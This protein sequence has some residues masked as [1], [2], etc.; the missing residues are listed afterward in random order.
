MISNYTNIFLHLPTTATEMETAK[1]AWILLQN[2]FGLIVGFLTMLLILRDAGVSSWGIFSTALS[3]GL[4]FSFV[5]DLGINTAHTR[6]IALGKYRNEYNN[7]LI[8]MKVILT[9]IYVGIILLAVFVWTTVLH[10]HFQSPLIYISILFLIPY[11]VGLPYIQANRAFFTGT[12]EAF[13]MSL[14]P[15]MESIARF[16]SIVIF[17]HFNIFHFPT[18]RSGIPEMA[19]LIAVSYSISYAVYAIVSFVVGMPWNFKWPRLEMIR[20]YL[21]YSYPLIGV[22]IATAISTNVPQVLVYIAF[23]SFQSGGFATDYRLILMMTGFTMSVTVLILPSLTSQFASNGDYGKTMGVSIK[24][25]TLF[26]TPLTVFAT[27]FAA[28]ILNLWNSALI[29][30]AFPLQVMLIGSWFWTMA[31]PFWTHFN[32]VAKT[33]ITALLTNVGY[34]LWIV[35]SIVLIPRTL[36][37]VHLGG[38]GV[39]GGAYSYLISGIALL[40][41]S[42]IALLFEV[43]IKVTY[44]SARSAVM[45]I[46]LGG[47]FYYFFH[48][49][50]R[51]SIFI[52]I[53]LF[54]AYGLSYLGLLLA[55]KAITKEELVDISSMMNPGKLGHY[56]MDELRKKSD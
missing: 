25:L 33:K 1:P 4:V 23:G 54:L 38:L 13:K 37:D 17:L 53:G 34:V 43:R 36:A 8:F 21:K 10:Q 31:I 20:T 2:G 44:Q 27:I 29:A 24:Y 9:I 26:V 3:F 41:T 6:M 48:G 22:S 49:Y 14:P 50:N 32:A 55:S 5:S 40:L 45:A 16:A 39:V 42:I 56:A 19:I 30:F 51:M 47:L 12:Q 52:M 18:S 28:P 11:F 7:A 46:L 15:I 35:L